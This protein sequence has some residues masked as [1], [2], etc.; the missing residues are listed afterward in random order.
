MLLW[1]IGTRLLF[2]HVVFLRPKPGVLGAVEVN[3]VVPNSTSM[4]SVTPVISGAGNRLTLLG[5][6]S[7]GSNTLA[8]CT[9]PGACG[10]VGLPLLQDGFPTSRLWGQ[11]LEIPVFGEVIAL[12]TRYG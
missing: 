7:H 10:S 8:R 1:G 3:T 4:Q 11:S 2:P 9:V 12:R 6:T 5:D